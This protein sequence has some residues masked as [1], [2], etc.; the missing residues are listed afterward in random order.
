MRPRLIVVGQKVKPSKRQRALELRNE[1]TPEERELWQHLRRNQLCGLHFRRQQ[2]IRGF[3]VDF[4]CHS[5]RLAV[6]L[7][8]DVHEGQIDYDASRD[9]AL[10]MQGIRVVRIK[11]EDVWQD[12]HGVLV[13]IAGACMEIT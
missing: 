13:R 4:Y 8:G 2:I 6:E 1:M 7:D 5:G 11:N 9:D 10:A 3:I 12:L